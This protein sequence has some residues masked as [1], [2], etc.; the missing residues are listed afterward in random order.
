[1]LPNVRAL[2]SVMVIFVPLAKTVPKSFVLFA[3]LILSTETKLAIPLTSIL[4][5]AD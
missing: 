1:M 2:V 4:E 5:P 3:R